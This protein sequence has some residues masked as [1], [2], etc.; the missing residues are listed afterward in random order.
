MD[1]AFQIVD[2]ALTEREAF[3]K[4]VPDRKIS[5]EA[6]LNKLRNTQLLQKLQREIVAAQKG[7]VT[8]GETYSTDMKTKSKIQLLVEKIA[9]RL[10]QLEASMVYMS[11][12]A[13]V[14]ADTNLLT[15]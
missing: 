11:R 13:A 1:K 2:D 6:T 15:K 3:C 12:T 8:L 14:S 7:V 9:N 4:A 10:E 5:R